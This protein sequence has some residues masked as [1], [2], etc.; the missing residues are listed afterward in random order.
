MNRIAFG[1]VTAT[2]A[3]MCAFTPLMAFATTNG[4][5][6]ACWGASASDDAT[7]DGGMG[8]HVKDVNAGGFID[9]TTSAQSLGIADR[10]GRAG[11]GELQTTCGGFVNLVTNVLGESC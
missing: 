11:I 8:D 4:S 3:S 2:L 1:I 5:G 6:G 7:T 9:S 10:P